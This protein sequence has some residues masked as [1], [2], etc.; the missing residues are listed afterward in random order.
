MENT[1]N[2]N[3]ID[4]VLHQGILGHLGCHFDGVTYVVPMCYA[5]EDGCIYGRTYEGMKLHM[6]R[7]NPRVCFQVEVARDMV[8]WRSVVCWGTFEVISDAAKR[9]AAIGV[10]Q[11][12][13]SAMI[14]SEALRHSQY[15]PF[16]L[17]GKEEI[18]GLL[19]CIRLDEKTGRFMSE[20]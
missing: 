6:I 18:R 12:R 8:H 11:R 3:E 5:Y 19:F 7:N 13:V 4:D 9:D 1:L 15:W 2:S 16:A 14:E 10:L 17:S 20:Y